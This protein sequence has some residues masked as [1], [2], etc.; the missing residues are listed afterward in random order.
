ME[1]ERLR[2]AAFDEM[3]RM[4]CEEEPPRPSLRLSSSQ[5]LPSISAQ[6]QIEPAKLKKLVSG[7]LDWIVMRSLEKDRGRRYQTASALADDIEHYLTD[8][9]VAASPPSKVYQ[10]QKFVRRNR[11]N[12]VAGIVVVTA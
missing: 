7:E 10:I 8:Q 3:L 12:V 9:P 5:A 2:S 4:I 1:K 6:R 11:S